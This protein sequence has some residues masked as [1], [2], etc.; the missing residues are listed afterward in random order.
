[1]VTDNPRARKVTL[2]PSSKGSG[3][4]VEGTARGVPTRSTSVTPG[5]M[6]RLG[7]LHVLGHV[8][9]SVHLLYLRQLGLRNH[10]LSLFSTSSSFRPAEDSGASGAVWVGYVHSFLL[11]PSPDPQPNDCPDRKKEEGEVLC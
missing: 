10:L 5:D 4:C 9:E 2:S 3:F 6:Y 11:L 8:P 7:E 1:M